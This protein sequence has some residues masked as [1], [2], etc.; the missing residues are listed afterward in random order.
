M[1]KGARFVCSLY[2]EA[3]R[4]TYLGWFAAMLWLHDEQ[5]TYPSC[6]RSAIPIMRRAHGGGSY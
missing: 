4:A 2:S 6:P 5:P 3:H 1:P